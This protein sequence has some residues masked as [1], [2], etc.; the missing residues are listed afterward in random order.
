[1]LKQ[2]S[3]LDASFLY[4]ETGR[5]F[6]HVNSLLLFDRPDDPDFDPY[7]HYRE[8]MRRAVVDFE[9]L[10]RRLVE[11]PFG[12]DHPYW[13]LD[14]DFDI[15]FHIRHLAVPPPGTA[16]QLDDQIA[17]LIGRPLDRAKPLWEAYV[18]EG[19]EQD[20]FAIF[21][22]MHHATIDGAAGAE[23]TRL[24]FTLGNQVDIGEPAPALP[25]A[26]PLPDSPQVFGQAV[27][28]LARRPARLVR[29]QRKL[30]SE[31]FRVGRSAEDRRRLAGQLHGVPHT[32]FNHTITPNRRFTW[33]SVP[34][35]RVKEIKSAL[36]V[37]VNDVVMAMSAGALRRYLID[38]D[39][40]PPRP[41]VAMIPVSI[42]TGEE[43]DP[44]TNRVSSIFVD[45][46]TDKSDPAARIAAISAAMAEGKAAFDLLPADTI[47]EA[48][49]L[50]P[51]RL[52]MQAARIATNPRVADRVV[53]P[54]NLVISNVPGP[55]EQLMLGPA[56]V[57][58]Y[59]PISTVI[60]GQGLNI[61]VQSYRDTLDIGL[62]ACRELVPD[63][64]HLVDL[65][66]EELD[67]MAALAGLAAE[68]LS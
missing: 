57:R 47:V 11:V 25:P 2:L 17:R 30:A 7:T 48:A 44:W 55:R 10:R 52:A 15:D 14:P 60:D 22:K 20:R 56:P 40:L 43:E 31:L 51:G 21:T 62:V 63:L 39:A 28:D 42:R 3:G 9:P 6:G 54:A 37:T 32:P 35:A 29:F 58:H 45:I 46:P 5:S 50:A 19:L 41:L 33:R 64:D 65:H 18:I 16:H 12:L 66:L 59:V 26:P 24:L 38:H 53:Q 27:W 1:M 68:P 34:L 4:L 13:A 23:L 61:T 49:S 67:A 36:G 8:R